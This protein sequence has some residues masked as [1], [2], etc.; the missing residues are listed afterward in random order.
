MKT[1]NIYGLDRTC[2]GRNFNR[3]P[4]EYK[5]EK[6]PVAPT[7]FVRSCPPPLHEGV[8]GRKRYDM[9]WYFL[10]IGFHP[11]AAVNKLLQK[12]HSFLTFALGGDEW[13]VSSHGRFKPGK[14]L[15]HLLNEGVR[16]LQSRTGRAREQKHVFA[17]AG[18][19]TPACPFRSLVNKPTMLSQFLTC[20]VYSQT[21]FHERLG[22]RTIRFTNKFSEHKA[23]RMTYCVSSYERASRQ[24]VDKNKSHWTTF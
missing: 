6:P 3:T 13:S 14:G 16:G 1:T 10:Q 18:T 8:L 5:P 17:P 7:H 24:N 12:F 21:S 19:R 23:S 9:T 20:S 15:R 22:S 11:A 2:S 4:S